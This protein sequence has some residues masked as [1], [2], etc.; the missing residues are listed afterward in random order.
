MAHRRFGGV[1]WVL[2]V[3][4][5]SASARYAPSRDEAHREWTSPTVLEARLPEVTV[6]GTGTPCG[7]T[8]D[9]ADGAAHA[10]LFPPVPG[11]VPDTFAVDR[12]RRRGAPR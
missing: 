12:T 1:R 2:T 7:A 5:E 9:A 8:P 3:S 10:V 11:V 4:D 6:P